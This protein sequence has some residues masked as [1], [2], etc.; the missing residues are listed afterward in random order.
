MGTSDEHI[1]IEKEYA[2]KIVGHIIA[3]A[4]VNGTI[5]VEGVG[6][7]TTIY[8]ADLVAAKIP[9]TIGT[10]LLFRVGV[11][12]PGGDPAAIDLERLG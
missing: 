12:H 9:A 1:L 5:R 7:E 10:R 3:M 11:R 4:E 6:Q 8:R 2:V